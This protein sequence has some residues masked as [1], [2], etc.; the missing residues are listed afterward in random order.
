MTSSGEFAAQDLVGAHLADLVARVVDKRDAL[1]LDHKSA[2]SKIGISVASL[3][4]FE[5]DATLAAGDDLSRL[6]AWAG[7]DL[8]PDDHRPGSGE[9]SSKG[10][11]LHLRADKNLSDEDA[12][13]LVDLMQNASERLR[14]RPKL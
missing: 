12:E 4:R 8:T 3:E 10:F 1:G 7:V 13:L 2:A 5:R 14:T 9:R 11:E 6:A